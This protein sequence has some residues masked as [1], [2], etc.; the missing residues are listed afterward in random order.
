MQLIEER[1]TVRLKFQR[2]RVYGWEH[3]P[4]GH[5]TGAT[6]ENINLDP[7]PETRRITRSGI[8]FLNLKHPP[9]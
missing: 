7:Q 5:G 1:V 4:S 2:V 9:V 8:D 6:V 3:W